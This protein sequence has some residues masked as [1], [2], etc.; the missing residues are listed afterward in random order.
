MEII[1]F[2]R[3]NGEITGKLFSYEQPLRLTI[4]DQIK[5]LSQHSFHM[6][7]QKEVCQLLLE[8]YIFYTYI[9]LYLHIYFIP[10]NFLY[11]LIKTEC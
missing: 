10:T 1:S 8:S 11:L 9:S 5:F 4:D 7:L 3:L 6:L 2:S